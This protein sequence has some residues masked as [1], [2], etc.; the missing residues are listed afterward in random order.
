MIWFSD[1]LLPQTSASVV[2]AG[3]TPVTFGDFLRFLGICLLMSMYSGWNVDQF[4]NYDV[5]P[6]NQE[7][8]PCPNNFKTFMPKRHFLSINQYLVFTNDQKPAFV[9]KFWSVRQIIK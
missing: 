5:V 1:V 8:D 2:N 4:W 7:E 3:T 9:D 6:H